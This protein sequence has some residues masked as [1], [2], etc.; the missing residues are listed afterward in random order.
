VAERLPLFPLGTVL[1]PGQL[2]PLHLFEPRYRVLARDLLDLPEDDRRFGVVAIRSGSEVGAEGVLALHE[3]G[4]VAR[5]RR[6]EPADD[7]R[8]AVVAT[9][10]ERFRLRGLEHGKPY[11]TGVVEPLPEAEGDG[12]AALATGARSAFLDYLR[13]LSAAGPADADLAEAADDPRT[14]SYLIAVAMRIDLEDR[15]SLLARPDDAERLRAGLS[16]LRRESRL[17]RLLSAVPAPE[18]AR[19]PLSPN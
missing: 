2:L 14:L 1:V 15:Q 12:A 13:A 10:A 11:L 4:C 5:V 17:I 3:V 18:L 8:F 19:A 16:L 7:G 9:G 6:I